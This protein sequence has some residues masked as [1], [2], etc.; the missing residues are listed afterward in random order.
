MYGQFLSFNFKPHYLSPSAAIRTVEM[1]C[2]LQIFLP[3]L[4]SLEVAL[5]HG[6]LNR[7]LQMRETKRIE[8][9]ISL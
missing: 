8:D 1:L 7:S 9:V 5:R 4:V 3:C 2:S 6:K